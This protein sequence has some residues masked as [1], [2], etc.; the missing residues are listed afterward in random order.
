MW[1]LHWLWSVMWILCSLSLLPFF[2]CTVSICTMWPSRTW[3]TDAGIFNWPL[4]PTS[5]YCWYVTPSMHHNS[6]KGV[7]GY[8]VC[9]CCSYQALIMVRVSSILLSRTWSTGAG[10]FICPL[11]PKT[12]RYWYVTS[13]MHQ[14]VLDLG[15]SIEYS[16]AIFFLHCGNILYL[17]QNV[18]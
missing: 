15:H 7:G 5:K 18:Q 14:K 3:S 1:E 2:H 9:H 16:P 4:L 13:S 12:K 6:P 8:V 10:I 11:L 17:I